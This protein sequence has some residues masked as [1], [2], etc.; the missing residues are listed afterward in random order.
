MVRPMTTATNS[1]QSPTT[2]SAADELE[3]EVD[4]AIALC[5][6]DTRAAL[7]AT[8]V[9]NAFL[10]QELERLSRAVS[11]GFTRGKMSPAR[12]ASEQIDRWREISSA[13]D[14]DAA[15]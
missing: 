9:A 12:R 1:G 5:G 15:G 4:Q 13:P 7:R 14:D 11:V 2:A 10:N 6:G 3:R 8:L